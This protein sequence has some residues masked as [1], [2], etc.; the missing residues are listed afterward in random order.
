MV[1]TTE[2]YSDGSATAGSITVE[3]IS[4][5]DYLY[6][7]ISRG[8]TSYWTTGIIKTT[9]FMNGKAYSFLTANPDN[10]A[11]VFSLYGIAIAYASDTEIRI[12]KNCDVAF[13]SSGIAGGPSAGGSLSINKIIGI[14]LL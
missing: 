14:K 9:D 2:L 8:S 1:S 5:Y 7:L 3:S 4:D 12:S 13:N 10:S 6:F 11:R